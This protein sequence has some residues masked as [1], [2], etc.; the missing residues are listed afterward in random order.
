M[1]FAGETG[2]HVVMPELNVGLRDA[3]EWWMR[4]HSLSQSLIGG[5][6]GPS[7]STMTKI[8]K[9]TGAIRPGVV[10]D[11]DSGLGWGEGTAAAYL[12]GS[13]PLGIWS[14][15]GSPETWTNAQLIAELERRL[16]RSSNRDEESHSSGTDPAHGNPVASSGAAEWGL[17]LN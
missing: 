10:A 7:T 1:R 14:P 2:E 11:L 17:P 16:A 13:D 5:R 15:D 12:A 9:A 8:A 4:K 6:G 3:V